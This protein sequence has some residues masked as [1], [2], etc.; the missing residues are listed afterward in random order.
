MRTTS[1]TH[2][3]SHRSPNRSPPK[4]PDGDGSDYIRSHSVHRLSRPRTPHSGPHTRPTPAKSPLRSPARRRL[5]SHPHLQTRVSRPATTP[6]SHASGQCQ[7][8]AI[9]TRLDTPPTV[10][11]GPCRRT[12]LDHTW[13]APD[14]R[15]PDRR[16]RNRRGTPPTGPLVVRG[17]GCG[18]PCWGALLAL[19]IQAYK[20]PGWATLVSVR[21]DQR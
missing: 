10:Q 13:H 20:R 11:A 17:T 5:M 6:T 16:A 15:L 18:W 21:E 3:E 9:Q 8:W 19:H 7:R 4:P 1:P 12:N 2:R 14:C